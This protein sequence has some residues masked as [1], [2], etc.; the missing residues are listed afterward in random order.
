MTKAT[1][2]AIFKGKKVRK[3]IYHNELWF[4]IVLQVGQQHDTLVL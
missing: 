1:K 4:N 2:I 3:T